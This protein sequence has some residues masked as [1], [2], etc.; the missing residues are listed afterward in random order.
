[1]PSRYDEQTRA[2]AVRLVQD[3]RDDYA[4]DWEALRVIS[5]RLGMNLRSRSLPS[6]LSAK[7]PRLV[8][9]YNDDKFSARAEEYCPGV[10]ANL[11]D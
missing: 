3:R 5:G 4:S 8:G 1:M 10:R 7:R 9:L 2:K 6:V 11:V